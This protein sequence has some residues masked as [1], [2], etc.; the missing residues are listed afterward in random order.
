[1]IVNVSPA[2]GAAGQSGIHGDLTGRWIVIA[3]IVRI[4]P[5]FAPL[6]N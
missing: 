4:C 3:V 2:A 6:V 1:M 5:E